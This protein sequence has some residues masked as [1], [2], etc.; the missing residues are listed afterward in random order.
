M[1]EAQELTSLDQL[2][3]LSNA[4]LALWIEQE[5]PWAVQH[6]R[7][8]LGSQKHLDE[9]ERWTIAALKEAALRLKRK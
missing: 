4:D 8:R 3:A 1:K 2:T 5:I 7:H 6:M 9:A